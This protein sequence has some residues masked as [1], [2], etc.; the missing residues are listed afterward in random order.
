MV[1][2]RVDEVRELDLRDGPQPAHREPHGHARDHGLGHRH[3]DDALRA[4]PVV[5]PF[6]GAKHAAELSDVLAEHDHAL[7]ARHLV[8]ERLAHGFDHGEVAHAARI[9]HAR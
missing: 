2:R 6:G 9:S 5:Q 1:H 7:V 3:V 4:E 8:T